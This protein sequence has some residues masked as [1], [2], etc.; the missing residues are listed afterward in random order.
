MENKRKT[1]GRKKEIK[2]EHPLKKNKKKN[3]H[4]GLRF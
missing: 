3:Q 1:K 4:Q 2:L